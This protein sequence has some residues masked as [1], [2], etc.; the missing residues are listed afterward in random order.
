MNDQL[1]LKL[2]LWVR[3]MSQVEL[4]KKSGIPMS[5]LGAFN[6]GKISLSE[7][8]KERIARALKSTIYDIFERGHHAT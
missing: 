2:A 6:T 1:S 5:V 3:K 7:P 4:A 8:D